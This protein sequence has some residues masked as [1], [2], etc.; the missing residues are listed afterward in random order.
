MHAQPADDAGASAQPAHDA[1]TSAQPAADEAAVAPDSPRAWQAAFDGDEAAKTAEYRPTPE[2][3]PSPESEVEPQVV[4]PSSL[5]G[6]NPTGEMDQLDEP[7]PELVE[8][9]RPQLSLRRRE[10]AIEDA[11]EAERA[12]RGD[13]E[14]ELP[15]ESAPDA[16][17]ETPM[18]A[19]PAS[20]STPP[21][22]VDTVDQPTQA[23]PAV[24]EPASTQPAATEPAAETRVMDESRLGGPAPEERFFV[25]QPEE[26]RKR[27]ARGVGFGVAL[28]STVVLAGLLGLA[29]Y[30]L[31]YLFTRDFD[32]NM[33]VTVWLQP[34]F[35]FPVVGFFIAY[36]LLTLIVNRA[37]WWAHVLGGFVVA[38]IVYAAAVWGLVYAANGGWETGFGGLFDF[39]RAAV[40]DAVLHPVAIAAFILAREVPIW[41]GG[42]VARRGR[43][44]R[45]RY[46][47][48]VE[49][50]ERRLDAA[51]D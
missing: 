30:G 48:E 21:V 12:V 22:I 50:Y 4:L 43:K 40:I 29:A 44:Q 32:P 11:K 6:E 19:H 25:E 18:E 3:A 42:I 1:A 10:R 45:N 38:A 35:V 13:E 28:L 47:A 24:T 34:Q 9:A 14:P 23:M 2:S 20:A 36:V 17:A 5:R 7:S 46:R 51:R 33:I 15:A 26:P 41:L 39:P 31:A 27:G 16:A 37:G 49:E 8:P